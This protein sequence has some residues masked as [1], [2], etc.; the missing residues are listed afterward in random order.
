M[1]RARFAGLTVAAALAAGSLA[2]RAAQQSRPA[3]GAR[4]AQPPAVRPAD[5]VLR[6][7]KIVTVDDAKPQAQAIAVSG[8]TI[9]AVGT[10][11]D[12]APYVGPKTSVI[13]L[14]R[15]LAVPGLVDGHA[16][17]T[18]VGQAAMQLRL[19]KVNDWDQ[20]V[21]MVGEAAKRA[22][23]GEWILGRGWHQEK[24]THT[25]MPNVEGFPLHEALSKAAPNNPVWLTHA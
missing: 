17:L 2:A 22:R 15:A 21:S 12:I 3:P 20:I 18:G 8:D 14:N 19:A 23:P 6:N 13:D 11:A 10:N 9:V 25:P 16:H 5:L 7:G 1:T 24:W 4:P